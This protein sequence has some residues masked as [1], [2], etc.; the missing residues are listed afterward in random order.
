MPNLNFESSYGPACECLVL[1]SPIL[2]LIF[3]G[4][5]KVFIVEKH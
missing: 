4:N 1:C 5:G 3:G 2:L